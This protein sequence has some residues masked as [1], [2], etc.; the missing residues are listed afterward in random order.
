MNYKQFWGI[1]FPLKS[2][3]ANLSCQT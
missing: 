1:Y 2:W 3:I